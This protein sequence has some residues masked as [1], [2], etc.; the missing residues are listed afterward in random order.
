M[1]MMLWNE[2][3]KEEADS[4]AEQREAEAKAEQKVALAKKEAAAREYLSY[5]YRFN[6]CYSSKDLSDAI[7][8]KITSKISYEAACARYGVPYNVGCAKPGCESLILRI[9]ASL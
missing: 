7:G 4:K 6:I 9:F 3:E 1:S 2:V 8:D 5:I